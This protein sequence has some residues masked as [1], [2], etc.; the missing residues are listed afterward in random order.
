MAAEQSIGSDVAWRVNVIG[1]DRATASDSDLNRKLALLVPLERVRD[2]RRIG[3]RHINLYDPKERK[4]RIAL[5]AEVQQ[6]LA[7]QKG[8]QLGGCPNAMLDTRVERG[9]S[10]DIGE[11][12][13]GKGPTLKVVILRTQVTAVADTQIP[14][15]RRVVEA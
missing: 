7:V 15:K 4:E 6:V 1:E 10:R 9:H 8:T 5:P 13:I 3:Y 2:G 14:P 12:E 11:P